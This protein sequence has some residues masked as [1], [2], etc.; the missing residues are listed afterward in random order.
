MATTN[1]KLQDEIMLWEY[2]RSSD[3]VALRRSREIISEF[4]GNNAARTEGERRIKQLIDEANLYRVA[5]VSIADKMSTGVQAVRGRVVSDQ[6]RTLISFVRRVAGNANVVRCFTLWVWRYSQK[7]PR[8]RHELRHDKARSRSRS[9][10]TAG[11]TSARTRG[12]QKELVGKYHILSDKANNMGLL[13]VCFCSWIH[14]QLQSMNEIL[15]RSHRFVH[16]R[17]HFWQEKND[18]HS[19]LA[20]VDDQ[21]ERLQKERSALSKRNTELKHEVKELKSQ[22]EQLETVQ[23]D[24]QEALR[25]TSSH[26]RSERN[27]K[28]KL[29]ATLHEEGLHMEKEREKFNRDVHELQAALWQARKERNMARVQLHEMRGEVHACHQEMARLE[30][31]L[32]GA[33]EENSQL[34]SKLSDS[35]EKNAQIVKNM[36][37]ERIVKER[38]FKAHIH[39]AEERHNSVED[40]FQAKVTELEAV[41]ASAMQEKEAVSKQSAE[42][43]IEVSSLEGQLAEQCNARQRLEARIEELFNELQAE[44]AKNFDTVVETEMKIIGLD[45]HLDA[46]FKYDV[47]T[48]MVVAPTSPKSPMSAMT[49]KR[50]SRRE[51]RWG[52]NKTMEARGSHY[53]RG[54][55]SQLFADLEGG[56]EQHMIHRTSLDSIGIARVKQSLGSESSPRNAETEIQEGIYSESSPRNPGR[57][58]SESLLPP[59]YAF[60]DMSTLM[61]GSQ[62]QDQDSSDSPRSPRRMFDPLIASETHAARAISGGGGAQSSA[63]STWL[64]SSSSGAQGGPTEGSFL[65]SATDGNSAIQADSTD[66]RF[67]KAVSSGP[68]GSNHAEQHVGSAHS[69]MHYSASSTHEPLPALP[70]SHA[71][72]PE[73]CV[74]PERRV[75]THEACVGPGRSVF[76]S[77]ASVETEPEKK[78][79]VSVAAVQTDKN[80]TPYDVILDRLSKALKD[81]YEKSGFTVFEFIEIWALDQEFGWEAASIIMSEDEAAKMIQGVWRTWAHHK[82]AMQQEGLDGASHNLAFLAEH[83]LVR[84]GERAAAEQHSRQLKEK[85]EAYHEA[86]KKTEHSKRWE[87]YS[88]PSAK[89][90]HQLH[91]SRPYS[92]RQDP[93]FQAMDID[94]LLK[95]SQDRAAKMERET[96]MLADATGGEVVGATKIKAR[97]KA[98]SVAKR[99]FADDF[100]QI[101]DSARVLI[102]YPCVKSL[103][104]AVEHL[105][106]KD[107][108]PAPSS[109]LGHRLD[110]Y[111]LEIIDRVRH[112]VNGYRDFVAKVVVDGFVAEIQFHL[113]LLYEEKAGRKGLHKNFHFDV[114]SMRLGSDM[115][116]VSSMRGNVETVEKLAR[117]H[118]LRGMNARDQS[119]RCAIHYCCQRGMTSC[120]SVFTYNGGDL[121]IGDSTAGVLDFGT[122]PIELALRN[123]HVVLSKFVLR[124][125][126]IKKPWDR[127]RALKRFVQNCILWWVDFMAGNIDAFDGSA[128]LLDHATSDVREDWLSIGHHMMAVVHAWDEDHEEQEALEH[129][130]HASAREGHAPRVRAFLTLGVAAVG[131]WCN[132]GMK[133]TAVDKAIEFGNKAAASVL[134]EFL[135]SNTNKSCHRP[136]FKPGLSTHLFQAAQLQDPEYAMAALAAGANPNEARDASGKTALMI[137]AA[138]GHVK[139]CERLIDF[140]ADACLEDKF[141]C[142]ASHYA[143]AL[144]HESKGMQEYLQRYETK[145]NPLRLAPIAG[146]E[147]IAREGCAGAVWRFVNENPTWQTDLNAPLKVGM[148][149][150]PLWIATSVSCRVHE[151]HKGLES[152]EVLDPSGMVVRA[153]LFWKANPAVPDTNGDT[154]LHVAA[155]RDRSDIYNEL[156]TALIL[157]KGGK[158][159]ENVVSNARNRWGASPAGILDDRR[160]LQSARREQQADADAVTLR[161][162]F[163]FWGTLRRSLD[164]MGWM[165]LWDERNTQLESLRRKTLT[166]VVSAQEISG[167]KHKKK[168]KHHLKDSPPGDYEVKTPKTPKHTHAE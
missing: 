55:G 125:M 75:E 67:S 70:P 140:K 122:L 15:D 69:G 160:K 62:I 20:N 87:E 17:Q 10:D 58:S 141:G 145:Q 151:L 78:P 54:S 102:V 112:P 115:V 7:K 65:K 119:G 39:S 92:V 164:T 117:A 96:Q 110:F 36:A 100:S 85:E 123:Q 114:E 163:A 19:K 159:T 130:L 116:L 118:G 95:T 9:P 63:V 48:K 43:L 16:E 107:L 6:F 59:G 47:G 81:D 90:I 80:K 41:L 27:L 152:E 104:S 82:R 91:E 131:R 83:S 50:S 98:R 49:P 84:L 57:Q 89:L 143:A 105:I 2:E 154:P 166:D 134:A 44:K 132:K 60:G 127:A 103:Y 13:H 109:H 12:R 51:D 74:F 124:K 23:V 30:G 142:R 149:P 136:L 52:W 24:M 32:H 167:S 73:N 3:Q 139:E 38:E 4:L 108:A 35:L 21:L 157:Q 126:Q 37:S 71:H 64:S 156:F 28:Y 135:G 94:F 25:T 29:E 113:A 101:T 148:K 153:L 121:W 56:L 129:Q 68:P 161:V 146:I 155:V 111:V 88:I 1:Q 61:G 26:L 147:H 79:E 128:A 137:F 144:G 158:F 22:K 99:K 11:L 86:W 162:I 72:I 45:T 106:K 168:K 33:R 133:K 138:M 18:L 77:D 66:V 40:Q 46:N 97:D 5:G 8:N 34:A 120:V 31:Y 150:T 165:E 53:S 76:T 93:S 42:A 14:A